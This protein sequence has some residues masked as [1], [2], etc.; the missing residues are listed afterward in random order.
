MRSLTELVVVMY[1]HGRLVNMRTVILSLALVAVALALSAAVSCGAD[2][3]NL[4]DNAGFESG[5][6]PWSSLDTPPFERVTNQA[7][8]GD[9]SALLQI[10]ADREDTG[11]GRSLLL[12]DVETEESPEVLSGFY[13]VEN[14]TKGAERQSVRIGVVVFGAKNLMGDFPNHQIHYILAGA[15]PEPGRETNV[16][17][18]YLGSEEPLQ[19]QWIPF[20]ADVRQD[21]ADLWGASPEGHELIRVVFEVRFDVK[22]EGST[23]VRG[24]VYL[25]DLY[26]GPSTD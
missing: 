7:V 19:N 8:T 2:E 12:Q 25:D 11:S 17:N 5:E 1:A 16:R 13:R 26:L 24:D 23:P 9:T 22:E 20:Q 3:T 18:I 14:W 6:D 21:F 15:V 4:L 10:V